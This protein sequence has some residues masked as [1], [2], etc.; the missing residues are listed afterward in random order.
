MHCCVVSI[1]Y[2][3]PIGEQCRTWRRSGGTGGAVC[4]RVGILVIRLFKTAWNN[5]YLA[6]GITNEVRC[7]FDLWYAIDHVYWKQMHAGTLYRRES[8]DVLASDAW[9]T[10]V[11]YK[12]STAVAVMHAQ[13]CKTRALERRG[14]SLF[15]KI[16]GETHI[17][18]HESYKAHNT[19]IESFGYICEWCR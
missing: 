4:S 19:K 16:M 10:L 13:C 6:L 8:V 17:C 12:V 2:C 1:V 14:G 5:A 3:L 11:E 18:S 15:A 9:T 7:R